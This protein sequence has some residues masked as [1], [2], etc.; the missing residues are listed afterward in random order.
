MTPKAALTLDVDW[1]YRKA[2]PW[3]RR[4]VVIAVND[5]FAAM[6]ALTLAGA[7]QLCRL[8]AN[9]LSLFD[10]AGD[11]HRRFKRGPTDAKIRPYDPNR[12]R[13]P[14]GVALLIVLGFFV[15]LLGLGLLLSPR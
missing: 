5:F 1:F 12:Y 2:A 3:L 4:N 9:P 14:V 15:L 11:G 10:F 13:R 7:R 8:G 6:D